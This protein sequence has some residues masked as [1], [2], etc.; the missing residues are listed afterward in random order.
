[1]KHDKNKEYYVNK[2]YV[3]IKQK[4]KKILIYVILVFNDQFIYN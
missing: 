1:M 4:Q 3:Y 2:F